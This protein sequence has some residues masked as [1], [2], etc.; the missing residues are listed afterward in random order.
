MCVIQS[1]TIRELERIHGPDGPNR[2]MGALKPLA[3]NCCCCCFGFAWNRTAIAELLG[4]DEQITTDCL[5]Y[6]LPTCMCLVMQEFY[7]LN[8]L[9]A[10]LREEQASKSRAAKLASQSETQGL[11]SP[12]NN[13]VDMQTLS[14]VVP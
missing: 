3:C 10:K 14:K 11:N 8:A 9:K 7:S 1:C 6:S 4:Y 2:D 13:E 12:A 5:K